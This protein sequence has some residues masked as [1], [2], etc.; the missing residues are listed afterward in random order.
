MNPAEFAAFLPIFMMFNISKK[1]V[2]GKQILTFL[3]EVLVTK[4]RYNGPNY[5]FTKINFMGYLVKIG[6]K[7]ELF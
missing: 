1:E 4:V 7:A 2:N 3:K 5:N 6:I